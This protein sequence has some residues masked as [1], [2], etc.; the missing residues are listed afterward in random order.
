EPWLPWSDGR[1][2]FTREQWEAAGFELLA[3]DTVDH[4]AARAQGVALGW[5]SADEMEHGIFAWY[6]LARRRP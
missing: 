1:S 6:T 3:L 4:A 2:P 5:G